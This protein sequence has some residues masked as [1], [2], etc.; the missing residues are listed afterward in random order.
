MSITVAYPSTYRSGPDDELPITSTSSFFSHSATPAQCIE[1]DLPTDLVSFLAVAQKLKID[2]LPITWQPAL[3]ELGEGGTA[4]IR[5]SL[6]TLRLSF[7]FKRNKLFSTRAFQA[8]TSEISVLG[9]PAIRY[10]Q[11]VVRLEGI[12]WDFPNEDE[13]VRP[14]LVF[15]KA[16]HGDLEKFS[17]SKAGKDLSF[18]DRLK[19]CVNVANAILA[20]HSCGERLKIS[21]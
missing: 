2:F 15:E 9:H 10:H 18:K 7:A 12:C 6:V 1:D 14:V 16:R 20:M 13:A 17:D 3:E 8:L 4:R 19:V 5:Q 11:N 21:L